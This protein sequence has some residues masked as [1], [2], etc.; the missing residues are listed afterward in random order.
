[1]L[2]SLFLQFQNTNRNSAMTLS[3]LSARSVIAFSLPQPV[4][5]VEAKHK[6]SA[7]KKTI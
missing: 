6:T 3:M 5:R 1:M 2:A 4:V 7:H